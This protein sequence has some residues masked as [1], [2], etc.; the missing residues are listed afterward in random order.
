M[1]FGVWFRVCLGDPP[2]FLVRKRVC[3]TSLPPFR[4]AKEGV[5]GWWVTPPLLVGKSH[6]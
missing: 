5:A 4:C 2:R 3:V 1:V 6:R